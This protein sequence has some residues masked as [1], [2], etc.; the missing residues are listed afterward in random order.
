MRKKQR[1][2]VQRK[3]FV[4]TFDIILVFVSTLDFHLCLTRANPFVQAFPTYFVICKFMRK[5]VFLNKWNKSIEI[6]ES[7]I[8]ILYFRYVY[9]NCLIIMKILLDLISK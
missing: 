2:N 9:Q 1:K 8:P 7:K 4:Y 5:P 6:R 3:V